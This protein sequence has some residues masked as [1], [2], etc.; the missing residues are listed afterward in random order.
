[1]EKLLGT[2][3]CE[4]CILLKCIKVKINDKLNT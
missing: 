1:M 2:I 3:L 4:Y